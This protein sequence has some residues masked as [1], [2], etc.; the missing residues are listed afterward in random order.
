MTL[1]ETLILYIGPA[2]AKSII[3][4][5]LGDNLPAS[6]LASLVDATKSETEKTLVDRQASNKIDKI[7]KEISSKL[8]PLVQSGEYKLSDEQMLV[9]GQA[10]VF[11]LNSAQISVD[12]LISLGLNVHKF[13][14]YL[15]NSRKNVTKD[16]SDNENRAYE[17]LI[18]EISKQIIDISTELESYERTLSAKLLDNQE[19]ILNQ[20]EKLTKMPE[21]N[22]YRFEQNYCSVIKQQLDKFEIFGLPQLDTISRKQSLRICP[23]TS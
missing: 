23:S 2:I 7:A 1:V 9:V 21:A 8:K 10:A 15:L 17:F 18:Y 16:L 3:K 13:Y 4:N 14:K 22:H 19:Q 6:A 11:T 12:V 20:L 5:W